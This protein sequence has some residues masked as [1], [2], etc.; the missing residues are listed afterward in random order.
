MAEGEAII[1]GDFNARAVEWG[2]P[3]PNSRGK[4][5]LEMAPRLG[6]L[7]ANDGKSSTFRRPEY[8]E[9]IPD[10]TLVTENLYRTIKG[11]QVIEDYTGSDHQYITFEV[12]MARTIL[13]INA[14]KRLNWNVARLD[15]RKLKTEITTGAQTLN[16]IPQRD[17]EALVNATMD[18]VYRACNA[19]M[20]RKRLR[21][22]KR[23][24]YWWLIDIAE[25]RKRCLYFRRKAQRIKKQRLTAT[26]QATAEND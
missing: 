18:L 13:G 10:I 4:R 19:S 21:N 8:T 3:K 15:E 17:T 9:T 2:M 16:T 22:N 14:T 6:L 1:A 5:V 26:T 12:Q 24:V 7:V 20:P 23:P 25:Q 11:W